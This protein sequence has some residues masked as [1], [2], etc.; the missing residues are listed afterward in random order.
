M[1]KSFLKFW[2]SPCQLIY[3]VMFLLVLIGGINVFSAS[4]GMARDM[5]GSGVYL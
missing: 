2:N 1:N 5:T 3:M 4:C